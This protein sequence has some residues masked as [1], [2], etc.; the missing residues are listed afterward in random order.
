MAKEMCGKSICDK[1]VKEILAEPIRYEFIGK[2]KDFENH[3]VD[4][5]DYING[6]L[7]LP[8][9]EAI[10]RQRQLRIDGFQ[11]IVDILLRHKDDT[12]TIIEVKKQNA[13]YPSS[14]TFNQMQAVGQMLLY[15]NVYEALTGGKPRLVLID[16][17]IFTRTLWAF[18]GNDLPITLVEFQKDRL[19]LPY[20]GW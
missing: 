9:I 19:F 2:E 6:A 1:N 10:F 15:Q 14:G 11:C 3:I 20:R 4:H 16:T 5:I 12:V 18:K 17:K 13:K 7:G 8:D